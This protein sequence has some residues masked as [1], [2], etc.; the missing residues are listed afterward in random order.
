[1]KRRNPVESLSLRRGRA[2]TRGGLIAI[3]R[4]NPA[5]LVTGKLVFDWR[6][7]RPLEQK[8]NKTN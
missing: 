2:V 1:M 4:G 3:S 6:T 5:A 8:G 7:L